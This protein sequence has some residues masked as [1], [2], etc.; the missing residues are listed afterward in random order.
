MNFKILFV[1]VLI[2]QI[3][4][5]QKNVLKFKISTNYIDGVSHWQKEKTIE[6]SKS[7]VDIYFYQ[8]YF[9]QFYGLPKALIKKQLKGQEI[10]EWAFENKSKETIENWIEFYKYDSKGK[11]IEYK[12][13]GCTICSQMPWGFKLIYNSNDRVIEQ[14]TFFLKSRFSLEKDSKIEYYLDSKIKNRILLTYGTEGGIRKLE[15]YGT[16]KIEE[17]IELLE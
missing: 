4:C 13:S 10:V 8:K 17:I 12:Y 16:N 9:S 2:F 15:K 1:I 6:Y 3:E 7:D 5:A 14:Q 11:L